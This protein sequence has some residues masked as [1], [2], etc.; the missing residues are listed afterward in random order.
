MSQNETPPPSAALQSANERLL[1]LRAELGAGSWS[2]VA[3]EEMASG[4]WSLVAGEEMSTAGKTLVDLVAALPPHL[5]WDNTTITGHLRSG[6]VGEEPSVTSDEPPTTSNRPPATSNQPPATSHQSPATIPL[7][8]TLALALLREERVA[9]GRLWLILRALDSEGRGW[10][11][12]GEITA[13]LADPASPTTLCTPRYLRQLLAQGEGLF[14]RQ[15]GQG[16]VWL[17]GQAKVAA[18]LGIRRL[19]GRAVELPLSVLFQPIGELRAHLY[20][21]FHSSRGE[22]AGPISRETLRDL[23]GVSPRAQQAYE[24]RAGVEARP[25]LA[26]GPTATVVTVQECA[27]QHG[28]AAFPFTDSRG[29]FGRP[30]QVHQARRL[31]NRYRGPHPTGGRAIRLNRQLA[32]LCYQGDAG[33]GRCVETG[34]R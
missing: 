15:D 17:R 32:G 33:N 34:E 27:W 18:G 4:D 12:R 30:G 14:W 8:P 22:E 25:C 9:E 23:S 1:A 19:N 16:K 10:W 7:Q 5:G 28:P 31:P 26:V 29:R 21:S 6:V 24:K 13:V 3:G 11:E 20:A 2:L